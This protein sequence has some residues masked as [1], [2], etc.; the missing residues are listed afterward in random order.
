MTASANRARKGKVPAWLR[1]THRWLG[2]TAAIF[3]VLLSVTGVLLNHAVDWQLDRRYVQWSWVLDA[4]G[5]RA[6]LPS[7]TYADGGHYAALLGDRVYFDDEMVM[8]DVDG[9]SGMVVIGD[10]AAV[11][12]PD[13]LVLLTGEGVLVDQ[14]DLR[15]RIAGAVDRLGRAG[16]RLAVESAGAM[17]TADRDITGVVATAGV[18][19][20]AVAWS[21]PSSLPPELLDMLGQH[22]RGHGL[23]VERL[24]LDLHSGRVFAL[25]GQL[26]MDLVALC[27]VLL[28][29]SGL[30]V[31]Y[32][33]NRARNGNGG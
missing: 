11:A 28:S 25:A 1:R 4:Y 21:R 31:W 12:T 26:F 8:R 22:Y 17:Y 30:V 33:G 15:G 23:T 5:I 9:L 24:L 7:A 20:T 19:A 32:R 14:I 10:I 16:G 2:V 18:P 6:P 29:L 27:L 3:V 13:R